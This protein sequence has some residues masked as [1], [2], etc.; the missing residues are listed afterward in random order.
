MIEPRVLSEQELHERAEN[1]QYFL[2][3]Q[4]DS[5]DV[6]SLFKRSEKLQIMIAESG[7]CLADAKWYK[8]KI[9]SGTIMEALKKSY[10]QKLSASTINKYVDTAAREYNFIVNWFDRINASATH[11]ND[12]VRTFI[13][14]IKEQMKLV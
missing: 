9:V 6:Q 7:K 5:N 14:F 8:D 13:S 3:E 2:E 4:Y 12:A 1:M 10:E 11:Q